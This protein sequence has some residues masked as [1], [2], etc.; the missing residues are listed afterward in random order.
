MIIRLKVIDVN[1][2]I[3]LSLHL[4]HPSTSTGQNTA[5]PAVALWVTV[6]L[7]ICLLGL[8][9]ALA[10]VCRRKI[11]ESCEE[12]AAGEASAE[13]GLRVMQSE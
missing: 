13:N 6:G 4:H 12:A 9:I 11:K 8:L 7:A 1:G 3:G 2:N 5:F 10:V